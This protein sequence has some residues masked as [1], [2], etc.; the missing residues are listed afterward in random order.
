M[1]VEA[2]QL[3][4]SEA[5]AWFANEVETLFA[6]GDVRFKLASFLLAF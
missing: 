4:F 6:R 1:V 3:W 2:F 5:W